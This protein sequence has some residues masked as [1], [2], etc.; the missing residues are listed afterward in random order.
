MH[1]FSA[2]NAR[3]T[4]AICF[5]TVSLFITLL[6]WASICCKIWGQES[7]ELWSGSVK[8]GYQTFRFHPTS[9]ISKYQTTTKLYF[10][11][12]HIFVYA[13]TL[14]LYVKRQW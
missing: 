12:I 6:T 4:S 7:S 13:H 9:M 1:A 11:S 2:N 8:L 5:Y 10:T 3:I 14:G